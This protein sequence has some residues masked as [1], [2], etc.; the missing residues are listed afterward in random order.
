MPMAAIQKRTGSFLVSLYFWVL[1]IYFGMILL[2]VFYA[3][4]APEATN[5]FRE[6][7]DL[8]LM[9]N[10]VA[11]LLAMLAIAFSKKSKNAIN[12]IIAS[13]LILFL[14]FLIPAIFA[15]LGLNTQNVAIG[16][17]LRIIPGAAASIVA[18]IGMIQYNRQK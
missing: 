14:Q 7:A 2:D 1:T 9:I 13:Q 16:P 12:L 10:F 17:W 11:L 4:L 15:I 18:F 8:L 3:R 6:V 5:A